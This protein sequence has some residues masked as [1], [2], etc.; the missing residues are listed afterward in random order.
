MKPSLNLQIEIDAL[1]C[2]LVNILMNSCNSIVAL[3]QL[4]AVSSEFLFEQVAEVLCY[5]FIRRDF[6]KLINGYSSKHPSYTSLGAFRVFRL[7]TLFIVVF[8]QFSKV[9]YVV[10]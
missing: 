3:L 8:S 1:L 7:Y 6:R 2:P 5:K 9:F 4:C 10:V